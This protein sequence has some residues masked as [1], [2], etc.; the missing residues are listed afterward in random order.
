MKYTHLVLAGT[1]DNQLRAYLVAATDSAAAGDQ[2]LSAIEADGGPNFASVQSV[3]AIPERA[4]RTPVEIAAVYVG[5][6]TT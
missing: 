6:P 2:V 1:V 5:Q 4:D 3:T